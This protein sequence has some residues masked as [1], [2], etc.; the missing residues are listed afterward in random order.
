[1]VSYRAY[2]AVTLSEIRVIIRFPTKSS[3]TNINHHRERITT[4]RDPMAKLLGLLV[5]KPE[6][7]VVEDE[8]H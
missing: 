6:E 1:M 5:E 7:E 2:D 8:S 4:I 3:S